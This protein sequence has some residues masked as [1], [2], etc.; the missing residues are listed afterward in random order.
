MVMFPLIRKRRNMTVIIN[1]S[2]S[3]SHFYRGHFVQAEDFP[4][5]CMQSFSSQI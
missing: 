4:Q 5:S 2:N 3:S 1:A